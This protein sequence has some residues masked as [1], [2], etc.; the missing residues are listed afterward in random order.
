MQKKNATKW[1]EGRE[2]KEKRA[3]CSYPNNTHKPTHRGSLS[4]VSFTIVHIF[5]AGIRRNFPPMEQARR[6][7]KHLFRNKNSTN[8]TRCSCAPIEEHTKM[9]FK[10][11]LEL[12]VYRSIGPSL[13][14]AMH[15]KKRR[16]QTK[17]SRTEQI[18]N[19]WVWIEKDSGS[20]E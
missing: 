6:S 11:A 7:L 19:K 15:C 16:K 4:F 18:R 13:L 2:R 9:I 5:F 17:Q 20:I 8:N 1:N 3:H 10:H 12:L 14:S